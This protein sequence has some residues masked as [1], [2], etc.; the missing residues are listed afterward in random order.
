MRGI[1]Q[2]G[3]R[4]TRNKERE[5]GE[6]AM[7]LVVVVVVCMFRDAETRPRV[8]HLC[9]PLALAPDVGVY[10]CGVV[11]REC[12]AGD[13]DGRPDE[14]A[15]WTPTDR[16]HR[17]ARSTTPP[18]HQSRP[19]T[20]AHRLSRRGA[21]P[22]GFPASVPLPPIPALGNILCEATAPA[23]LPQIHHYPSAPSNP[24]PRGRRYGARLDQPPS[25]PLP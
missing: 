25:P 14:G 8:V 19:D 18:W 21:E 12:N 4:G 15:E 7:M 13:D 16:M 23:V 6:R 22:C 24:R 3:R 2:N 10:I 9:G 17:S 5:R 1:T 20:Q 11:V